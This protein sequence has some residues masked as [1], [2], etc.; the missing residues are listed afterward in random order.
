MFQVVFI[1]VLLLINYS[2]TGESL[3]GIFN[4]RLLVQNISKDLTT[5]YFANHTNIMVS[6]KSGH[7]YT[8]AKIIYSI[9][10]CLISATIC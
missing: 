5:D 9:Y 7:G 1:G 4:D 6:Y 10:K 3:I 2:K 8:L